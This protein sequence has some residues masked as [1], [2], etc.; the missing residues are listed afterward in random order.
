MK[1]AA[2][3][4]PG[5]PTPPPPPPAS[6]IPPELEQRIAKAERLFTRSAM[7]AA[8]AMALFAF[9][10]IA[11]V[12]SGPQGPA[13][14]AG[15][16]APGPA[17]PAGAVGPRGPAGQGSPGPIG[18][19]GPAGVPGPQGIQGPPGPAGLK[20]AEASYILLS[21]TDGLAV[22]KPAPV[23]TEIKN[24]LT[25][26]TIDLTGRQ[27]VRLQWAHSLSTV[28][29]K[30]GVDYSTD[31]GQTWAPLVL[32]FGELK[33]P[34]GNQA[35]QWIPVPLGLTPLT[36]IRLVVYGDGVA[37]PLIRYAALDVR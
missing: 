35:S 25:R 10:V 7:I 14:P 34:N 26:R 8:G 5:S 32:G 17:G 27:S 6:T 12:K 16:G 11:L 20:S 3:T 33:E 18:P 24:G 30:M 31:F 9:V 23:A 28:A 2:K 21:E 22:G 36:Q 1:Q 15:T 4:A 19:Q 13:G 29:V 37:A